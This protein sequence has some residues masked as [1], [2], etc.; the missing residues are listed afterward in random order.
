[1]AKLNLAILICFISETF[2]NRFL[3]AA[4]ICTNR[5]N[6]HISALYYA[7]HNRKEIKQY[8][9]VCNFSILFYEFCL[10]LYL[11]YEFCLSLYLLAFAPMFSENKQKMP[12]AVPSS[13]NQCCSVALLTH[14]SDVGIIHSGYNPT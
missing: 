5:H 3:D 1:M 6:S 4:N 2:P 7:I 12:F 8:T 14:T 13:M 9:F 10:S 11:F